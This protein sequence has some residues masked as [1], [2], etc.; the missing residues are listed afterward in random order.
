MECAKTLSPFLSVFPLLSFTP[1]MVRPRSAS[2][3][4]NDGLVKCG[5]VVDDSPKFVNLGPMR[6]ERVREKKLQRLEVTVE[7]RE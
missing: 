4:V 2:D 7:E 3:A 1:E 5:A 6:Q